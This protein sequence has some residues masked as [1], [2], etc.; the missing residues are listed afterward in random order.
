MN[1][2]TSSSAASSPS[3]PKSNFNSTSHSATPAAV[4][5]NT[6]NS[7]NVPAWKLKNTPNSAV[8]V[9]VP[10]N[11]GSQSTY[12]KPATSTSSVSSSASSVSGP[13]VVPKGAIKKAQVIQD[14]TPTQAEM[15][16]NVIAL[17]KGQVIQIISEENKPWYWG[18]I[19]APGGSEGYFP[20]DFVVAV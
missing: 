7:G 14:F 17:K 9:N 8:H 11:S 6:L 3:L 4:A 1:T 18:K 2:N 19:L 15:K 20:W 10:V 16:G 12:N 13:P 5:V